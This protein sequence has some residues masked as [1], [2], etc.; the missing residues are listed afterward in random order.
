MKKIFIVLGII[1]ALVAGGIGAGAWYIN[2]LLGEIIVTDE[3]EAELAE[4][5]DHEIVD[6]MTNKE[7]EAKKDNVHNY[8]LF[9]VDCRTSGYEGCR[10]DTIMVLSYNE[11]SNKASLISV[12]RDT[13]VNISGYGLDKINHSY[14]YG[15][16]TLTIQTLNRTLDLDIEEYVSVNFGAVESIIDAIGGV[17]VYIDSYEIGQVNGIWSEGLHHLN[18]EQALAY[19]RIRYVGNGDFERMERQREVIESAITSVSNLNV[20]ELMTLVKELLPLVRTNMPQNEILDLLNTVMAK[21]IPTLTD[22]QVPAQ[23]DGADTTLNGV[24]YFVPRDLKSSVIEL[25]EL[26]HPNTEYVP[27]ESV[28]NLSEQLQG[29]IY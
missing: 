12:P 27:S 15:G 23:D 28:I 6:V 25:H 7:L 29:V 2:S 14:S 5:E 3:E 13:Y 11:D 16:A 17:E 9:G 18:G 4:K 8:A 22:A 19:A 26:I 1:L 20:F 21:G 24:Y 10:S